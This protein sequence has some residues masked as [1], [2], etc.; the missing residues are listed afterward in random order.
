MFPI[1]WEEIIGAFV[2]FLQFRW[3]IQWEL[4]E[5]RIIVTVDASLFFF[6]VKQV[7]ANATIFFTCVTEYIKNF[8]SRNPLRNA[9]LVDYGIVQAQMPLIGLGTFIEAQ[10]NEILPPTVVF[11]LLFLTLLYA[12]YESFSLAIEVS[13]KEERLGVERKEIGVEKKEI[14]VDRRVRAI[15]RK[16]ERNGE[17][18]GKKLLM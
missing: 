11:I 7:V 17:V 5:V 18:T 9:T 1:E 6:T 16:Q 2:V 15:I 13:Q 3:E 4:E 10:L 8:N 12:T 14:G